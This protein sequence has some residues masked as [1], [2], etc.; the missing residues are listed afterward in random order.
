MR[1]FLALAAAL[2]VSTAVHATLACEGVGVDRPIVVRSQGERLVAQ[3]SQ[4]ETLAAA[5]A[6]AALA[7]DQEILRLTTR[8]Q[9]LRI[10]A[11][12]DALVRVEFLTAAGELDARASVSRSRAMQLRARAAL[13]RTQAA[14]LRLQAQQ[15]VAH[16][17]PIRTSA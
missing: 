14:E 8:A 3:A 4:L 5:D 2:A 13:R 10:E 15:R 7:A 6:T 17:R 11:R 1:R 16:R 12:R 9:Q